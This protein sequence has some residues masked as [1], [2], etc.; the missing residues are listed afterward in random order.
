MELE[1][2]GLAARDLYDYFAIHGLELLHEYYLASNGKY[3]DE[4]L[5]VNE[6][7]VHRR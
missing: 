3:F 2:E 4:S 7:F 5:Y 6:I 1:R